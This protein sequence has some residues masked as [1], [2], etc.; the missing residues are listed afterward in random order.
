MA[1]F[2]TLK[3][4]RALHDPIAIAAKC[5]KVLV[6]DDLLWNVGTRGRNRDVRTSANATSTALAKGVF[7]DNDGLV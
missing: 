2:A 4:S 5:R 1:C 3:N 6:G 7:R